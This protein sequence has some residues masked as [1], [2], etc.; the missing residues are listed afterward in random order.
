MAYETDMYLFLK[1]HLVLEINFR[2][3]I[4]SFQ[5]QQSKSALDLVVVSA[6]ALIL[7]QDMTEKSVNLA[8]ICLL[9]LIWCKTE[10]PNTATYRSV[11]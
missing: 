8:V 10:F 7:D 3:L 9:I 1:L 2:A 4:L 11:L 6:T 5:I